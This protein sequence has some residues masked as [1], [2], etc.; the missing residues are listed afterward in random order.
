MIQL[1]FTLLA[2]EAALVFV[3]LFRTPARRLALL[4]VDGAKRGRG[5]VMARTVAATML[6]VLGSSGFSIAKIR[7]RAGELGQLTPTDQVLASRYL[8]EASLMG[9]VI[10]AL[11]SPWNPSIGDLAHVLW[12]MGWIS[13]HE[14]LNLVKKWFVDKWIVW[15]ICWDG[16]FFTRTLKDLFVLMR[17]FIC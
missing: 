5:P 10:S 4:A 3:L 7:H 13:S 12:D 17:K 15:F 9:M 16:Y 2:A 8:L 14:L 6:V 11:L 1:L